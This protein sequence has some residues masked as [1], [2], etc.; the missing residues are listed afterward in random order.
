M[1][2][3]GG[4]L[5]LSPLKGKS[6]FLKGHIIN[7]PLLHIA[8]LPESSTVMLFSYDD[9]AFS[10]G[11]VQNFAGK[12]VGNL[13]RQLTLDCTAE[14]P[15][16]FFGIQLTIC[17]IIHAVPRRLGTRRYSHGQTC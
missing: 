12:L 6:I 1:L 13:H 2:L 10:L 7:Y 17:W 15:G 8:S 11:R 16:Q 4:K 14:E 5:W 3:R 9:K